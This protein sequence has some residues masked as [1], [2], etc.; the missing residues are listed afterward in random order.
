MPY[1]QHIFTASI[2]Q[3]YKF[4]WVNL[5]VTLNALIDF[6]FV[7][8]WK[9]RSSVTVSSFEACLIFDDLRFT[10]ILMNVWPK[11]NYK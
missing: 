3:I 5:Q 8:I 7:F 4:N 10:S 9:I 11:N 6:L 2:H 1:L